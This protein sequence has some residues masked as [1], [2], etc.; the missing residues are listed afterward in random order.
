MKKLSAAELERYK[1]ILLLLRSRFRGDINILMKHAV[2]NPVETRGGSGSQT[3]MADQGS[4]SFDQE[5]SFTMLEAGSGRLSEIEDAL[6]R[7][8]NGTYGICEDCQTRIPK[9]RL[10]AIP[11]TALCVKCSTERSNSR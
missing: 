2:K 7:I 9:A 3:H 11:Y 8:E 6:W 1:N 4:D 10:D 5:L